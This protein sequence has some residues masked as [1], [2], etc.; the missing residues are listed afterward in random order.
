[1][2]IR[3]RGFLPHYE[4]EQATYFVTFRLAGSLPT[5]VLNTWQCEQDEIIRNVQ[6][7]KGE[8][9]PFEKRRLDYLY[10]ERVEKYLDSGKG[11]CWLSIPQVAKL[12]SDA[13]Q[14]FDGERYVIYSWCIMPN[15]VHVLFS[16]RRWREQSHL[17]SLLIPILHSWKSFT[18]LKAN[19]I[20]KR[21]GK[22]WQEEYFDTL[23]KSDKQFAFY[24][25]YI[26][27]NPVAAR[28]CQ[29]WPDWPWSGCHPSIKEMLSH[30]AGGLEARAPSSED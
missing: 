10:L 7:R 15:H 26:L 21:K 20:L 30:E 3:N 23:V 11:E 19:Q 27:E 14:Y 22:F 24:V 29:K 4:K 1:M 18:A 6:L 25:R 12:V 17:D 9:S 2:I 13:L 8:I 5:K 16:P 28:L